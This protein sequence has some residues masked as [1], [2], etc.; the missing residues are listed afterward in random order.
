MISALP[1]HGHG[2]VLD[3]TDEVGAEQVGLTDLE[4]GHAVE[5]LLEE[6]PHLQ[7]GE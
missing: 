7:P 6:H 4:F 2:Q 5:K 1:V 3:P